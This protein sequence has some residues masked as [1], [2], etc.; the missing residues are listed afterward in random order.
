MAAIELHRAGRVSDAVESYRAVL[1]VEPR[2]FDARRLLG[3]ALLKLG[4]CEQSALELE[5]ALA[6]SPRMA[7]VWTH[8]GQ[9]LARLGRHAPAL[10]CFQQ[11]ATLAPAAPGNWN[12]AGLQQLAL[13]AVAE[14]LDSFDRAV[15][16]DPRFAAAWSNRGLALDRLRRA[17][18][19][20]AAHRQAARLAPDSAPIQCNLARALLE[21]G[22]FEDALSSYR[23]VAQREERNEAAWRGVA[24]ALTALGRLPE[25]IEACDRALDCAASAA[26]G[27][28]G[29]PYAGAFAELRFNRSLLRLTLG[30]YAGG[31]RDFEYRPSVAELPT[32][33]DRPVAWE[34]GVP[35][36]GRSILLRHE[37]GVGDTLQFCRFVPRLAAQGARVTLQVPAALHGLLRGLEGVDR[38]LAMDELPVGVDLHCPLPGLPFRLGVSLQDLPGAVPY[39]SAPTADAAS[40]QA[41]LGKRE[42][43]RIGLAYSGNP[44]HRNDA[45]RSLPARCLPQLLS[46]RYEWHLLQK[47][48]SPA[49][50]TVLAGL[51]I[52]D[53]RARLEDFSDTAALAQAMDIVVSVDTS[54]AHLAGALGRPLRV[55]LPCVPDWRW[56]LEREDSPWYPTARLFRQTRHGDWESPIRRLRQALDEAL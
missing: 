32:G 6:I 26:K 46:D 21:H 4:D 13:D 14:A 11:A 52:R 53:H 49:D 20:L 7:E 24:A 31:W 30:D 51:P 37:Q 22:R 55:L 18:E 42:R 19:A 35:L 1:D 54:V 50:E 41:R 3:A 10:A 27:G 45:A 44:D 56:L 8:R 38:I 25:A 23:G 33:P 29:L 2:Q 39:L 47:E 28:K 36:H 17:E 48:V 5:R 43:P 12:E 15:E 34:P 16:L 9:A 40:W